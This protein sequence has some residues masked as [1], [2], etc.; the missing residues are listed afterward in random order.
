M[1]ED[2]AIDPGG[3]RKRGA[4]KIPSC[5]PQTRGGRRWRFLVCQQPAAGLNEELAAQEGKKRV[6]P[7]V[8]AEPRPITEEGC[9]RGPAVS[10]HRPRYGR[11]TTASGG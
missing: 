6:I 1:T 10:R 5:S 4:V 3:T 8:K 2:V 11:Q 7:A 9:R